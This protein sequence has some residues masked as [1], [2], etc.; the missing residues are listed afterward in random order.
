VKHCHLAVRA[1]N[2]AAPDRLLKARE[3]KPEKLRKRKRSH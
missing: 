2:R 1:T 3:G